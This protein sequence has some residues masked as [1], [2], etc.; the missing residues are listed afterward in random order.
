MAELWKGIV[1]GLVL[2]AAGVLFVLLAV[3]QL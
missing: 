2:T 1:S 3:R